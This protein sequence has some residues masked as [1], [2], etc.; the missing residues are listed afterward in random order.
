M[1]ATWN[2]EGKCPYY[3]D[4]YNLSKGDETLFHVGVLGSTCMY[5]SSF[6]SKFFLQTCSHVEP[7]WGSLDGMTKK[8]RWENE[9]NLNAKKFGTEMSKF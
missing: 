3:L 8:L 6:V 9:K 1:Y 2:N 7:F 4:T 5:T